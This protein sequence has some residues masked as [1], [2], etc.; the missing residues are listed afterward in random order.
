MPGKRKTIL[1]ESRQHLKR[2]IT[3]CNNIEEHLAKLHSWYSSDY[4]DFAKGL[5]I[6]GN[7]VQSLRD[8]IKSLETHLNEL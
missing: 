4:E 5:A 1:A 8:F 3:D 7:T 2:S 6:A